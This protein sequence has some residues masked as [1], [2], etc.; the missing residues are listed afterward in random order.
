MSLKRRRDVATGCLDFSQKTES[1]RRTSAT[2][3]AAERTRT[4][5]DE[6]QVDGYFSAEYWI[7]DT[8][9]LNKMLLCGTGSR[10]R[11]G[12]KLKQSTGLLAVKNERPFCSSRAL[13]FSNVI[14]FF[15][16]VHL[17]SRWRLT[18]G[19]P[20]RERASRRTHCLVFFAGGCGTRK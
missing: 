10:G 3:A 8:L 4:R 1:G 19:R 7:R 5:C 11:T 17:A 15:F 9:L 13:M 2:T 16:G 18:L 6:Q 12:K 14:S 20:L